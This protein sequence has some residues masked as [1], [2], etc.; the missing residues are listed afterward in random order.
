[1]RK[2]ILA[3]ALI[4]PAV[5]LAAGPYDGAWRIGTDTVDPGLAY[6]SVHE[7]SDGAMVIAVLNIEEGTWEAYEGV[8]S[9]HTAPM[10]SIYGPHNATFEVQF[11]SETEATLT[12]PGC[13]A[14]DGV[15]GDVPFH[16]STYLMTKE[17]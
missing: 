5:S 14:E 12:I 17:F 10:H 11:L 9:G 6:L 7:R 8:R 2:A 16:S 1:M 15:C 4:F 13:T 3:L